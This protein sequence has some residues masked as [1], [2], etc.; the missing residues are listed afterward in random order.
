MADNL[1]LQPD[2]GPNV[3]DTQH[4][5]RERWKLEVGAAVMMTA[6]AAAAFV[7]GR[8]LYKAV[9]NARDERVESRRGRSAAGDAMDVVDRESADSFPASDSPSWTPVTKAKG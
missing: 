7:G 3:W 2:R 4:E 6:G 5:R 8:R 1:N 9:R